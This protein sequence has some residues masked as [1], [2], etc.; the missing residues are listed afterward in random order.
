[1]LGPM[2][3]QSAILILAWEKI[4][5]LGSFG[6]TVGLFLI[7]SILTL[8]LFRL[9]FEKSIG[10]ALNP[11]LLFLAAPFA[12][13]SSSYVSATQHLDQ[14][15]SALYMVGPF[16]LAVMVM[17]LARLLYGKSFNLSCL[18]GHGAPL[19]DYG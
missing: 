12:V 2:N 8:L 13:G 19:D 1:M 14:F 5:G 11:S 4:T 16:L 10:L 15:A 3:I 17:W 6:L 18:A 7:V 9:I